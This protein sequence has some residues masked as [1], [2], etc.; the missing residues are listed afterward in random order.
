MRFDLNVLL[1]ALLFLIILLLFVRSLVRRR[2]EERGPPGIAPTH[3]DKKTAP[4]EEPRG[5]AE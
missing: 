2:K 5:R 1:Y 3:G 4:E